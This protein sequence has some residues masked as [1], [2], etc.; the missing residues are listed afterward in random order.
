MSSIVIIGGGPAGLA[1]AAG[2]SLSTSNEITVIEKSTYDANVS[3]EHLRADV[4]PILDELK[5]PTEILFENSTP[6]DGI[7]GKWANRPIRSESIFNPYGPDYIVHRP[8]FEKALV[9]H[10]EEKGVRFCLGMT[11]AAIGS[12]EISLKN[13][14]IPYDLLFDCSGR[15]SRTFDNTRL[16]FDNLLGVSFYLPSG[17]NGDAEVQIE[18]AERGWWYYTRH[19]SLQIVTFFTDADIY[20]EIRGDLQQEL[21]KTDVIRTRCDRLNDSRHISP[22]YTSILKTN[23]N[24]IYQVGDSYFSLDPLSSQGMYKAF[25]QAAKT[26]KL[27]LEGRF[28][29][30]ITELYEEQRRDFVL[31]LQLRTKFYDEGLGYYGS[32]FYRRRVM[33]DQ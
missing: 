17:P 8:D 31:Q 29:D 1:L 28:E 4:V 6:C 14:T 13:K 33:P 12:R 9:R 11:Y 23:P 16:I 10:L 7:A 19:R 15:T 32:E 27:V 22:A 21:D 18:S 24:G 30:S 20:K 3:G 5:I 2:L 26:S 25:A